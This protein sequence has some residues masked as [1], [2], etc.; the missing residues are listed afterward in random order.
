[1]IQIKKK[2]ELP[3]SEEIRE[4]GR[5]YKCLPK[6]QIRLLLE[7]CEYDLA[8]TEKILK[9]ITDYKKPDLVI[10]EL[11]DK[12]ELA[13]EIVGKYIEEYKLK[14]GEDKKEEG[15]E[16]VGKKEEEQIKVEPFFEKLSPDLIFEIVLFLNPL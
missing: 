3:Y 15:N 9:L 4:L 10:K 6:F 11:V 7:F 13:E 5:S 2:Q 16:I 8:N 1:M 12:P 14:F